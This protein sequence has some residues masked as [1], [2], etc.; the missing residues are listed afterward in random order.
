MFHGMP[1]EVK[2]QLDSKLLYVLSNLNSHPVVL[3]STEFC[4]TPSFKMASC[5]S[6]S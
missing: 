3:S 5:Y 2:G 4:L 1:V 6:I